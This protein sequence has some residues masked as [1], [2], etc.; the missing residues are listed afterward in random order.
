VATANTNLSEYDIENIPNGADFKIGIVVSEWNSSITFNLLKGAE[1]TLLKHGVEKE[2]ISVHLTPGSFELAL[3]AQFL[4]EKGTFDGVVALGSV[5]QGETKHFDF[6]CN[7]VAIGIKDV[8]LKYNKPVIFGVL[9]DNN[10][11][12]AKDRSGGKHGNKGIECAVACLK[13]IEFQ[14]TLK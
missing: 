7:S 8:S 1:E 11:Q 6:V 4:L 5:I 14:N 10:M 9:T 2:N 13:M 3:G 12:Q